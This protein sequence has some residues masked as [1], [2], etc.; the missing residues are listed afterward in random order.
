MMCDP[1]RV[2]R[3][4]GDI[5]EQLGRVNRTRI[6]EQ[7][8]DSGESVRAAS[9]VTS[10][11]ARQGGKLGALGRDRRDVSA[12]CFSVERRVQSYTSSNHGLH[13]TMRSG[14]CRCSSPT[15]RTVGTSVCAARIAPRVRGRHVPARVPSGAW[16]G[17]ASPVSSARECR[18]TA[19]AQAEAK[20]ERR[21]VSS[22]GFQR[23]AR[24]ARDP[25]RRS[26]QR[27]AGAGRK[28]CVRA[29][30][31]VASGRTLPGPRGIEFVSGSG[32][33]QGESE[34]DGTT[35]GDGGGEVATPRRGDE[36]HCPEPWRGC[37]GSPCVA[38][39]PAQRVDCRRFASDRPR[40]NAS[41]TGEKIR[42]RRETI[43]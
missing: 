8:P 43:R 41:A 34:R 29:V 24:V 4:G 1:P 17:A 6:P 21:R 11:L 2:R 28:P 10:L 35:T 37:A 13:P 3:G 27:R 7:R 19:T 12:M 20:G 36:G 30:A 15:P 23:S 14:H 18:L 22:S 33:R 9:L 25:N 39:A 32:R 31:Q 26:R 40:G 42:Q 5:L 16:A 38:R